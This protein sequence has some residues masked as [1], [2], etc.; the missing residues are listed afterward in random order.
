MKQFFSFVHKEFYHIFRD[1]RT[2]LILL[3]MPVALMILFGFAITTEVKN[4]RVAVL[5]ESKDELTRQIVERFAA[6]NYFTITHSVESATE[7]DQ[8]FKAG[9]IDMALCFNED[10]SSMREPAI[11]LLCDGLE[12]NQASIRS[13]YAMQVLQAFAQEHIQRAP[14]GIRVNTRMLYNPQLKSE[15]NFVPGVIGM[16][17][18]LLCTLM[19]SISIVRE[20]EMGTMEVLLASP[21]PPLYIVLAKLVP[22]FV[23]SV[24]NLITIL[25]LS[26]FLL[27]IPV[28][29]SLVAFLGV[30]LIYILV[31]LALGLLISTLVSTQLVAMLLSVLMIIPTIYFSGMIFPVESMPIAVQKVSMIVPARWYID[32]TRKLMIQGVETHYVIKDAVVLVVE[33]FVLLTVS[34]K[35]FKIR[36]Q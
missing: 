19:T 6:N 23:I 31:A 35:L 9:Q 10:F 20:K 3:L 7:L 34:L 36:L 30:S 24:I 28:A 16:I 18:I 26:K 13:G 12:P 1:S 17:I 2:M 8:L 25:L 15:Y 5:D 22:Y 29:G 32:A 4:T 14:Q 33:L 21:L 11:Q 27:G